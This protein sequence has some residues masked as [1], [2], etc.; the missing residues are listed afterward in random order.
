MMPE[1]F[2]DLM[3]SKPTYHIEHCGHRFRCFET[4]SD[5]CELFN[6]PTDARTSLLF[7]SSSNKVATSSVSEAPL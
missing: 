2:C 5:S 1:L 3:Y 4:T 7:P 6:C